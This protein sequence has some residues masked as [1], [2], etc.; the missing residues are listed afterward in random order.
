MRKKDK[1][2][3]VIIGDSHARNCAAELHQRLGKRC[4]VSGFVKPGAGMKV[5][6]QSC[7]EEIRNLCREDIVVVWGAQMILV[8]R[9]PRRRY[10]R[11]VNL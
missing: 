5:I 8:N 2:K 10:I 4:S 6:V 11:Y 9:T 7:N 1:P 3:V